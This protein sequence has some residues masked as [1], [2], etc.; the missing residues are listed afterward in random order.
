MKFIIKHETRG[1]IRVHMMQKSMTLRQAD[2]LQYAL[3]MEEPIDS[4]KVQERT[5]DVV[6][7]YHGSRQ[8]ILNIL[9]KFSYENSYVP[10]ESLKNSGRQMNR[11]Y[12]DK[13]I[14]NVV[15]HYGTKMFMP[16]PIRE[17][18]AVVKS[19][20]YIWNGLCTLAKGKIEVPVLDATAIGVSMLRGDVNTAIV[21]MLIVVTLMTDLNR[22]VMMIGMSEIIMMT[23][24][25]IS[26]S[27]IAI[28]RSATGTIRNVTVTI[29]TWMNIR[30]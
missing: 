13:L 23:E 29:T 14:R 21:G 11:E 5:C 16:L 8:D 27:E 26:E 20:K 18:I 4:A 30:A 12:K 3:E 6:I 25:N 24:A 1:R 10:E 2:I 9:K 17:G 22:I 15:L 7:C 28:L 19:A